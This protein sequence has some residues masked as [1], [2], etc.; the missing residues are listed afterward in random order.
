MGKHI[1]NNNA[2]E[3]ESAEGGG[4]AYDNRFGGFVSGT[5]PYTTTT[6]P[7]S[8]IEYNTE[9][10]SIKFDITRS[11]GWRGQDGREKR[12]RGGAQSLAN[13]SANNNSYEYP[14]LLFY[15]RWFLRILLAL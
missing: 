8:Y 6:H 10:S 7:A 3:K 12:E 5:G 15:C 4:F 11:V 9:Q 13:K 2:G 1:T 14:L